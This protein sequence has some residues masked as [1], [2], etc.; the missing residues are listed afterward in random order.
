MTKRTLRVVRHYDVRP[1]DGAGRRVPAE[2]A[3]L[4]TCQC[5]GR[6]IARVAVMEN[7][8]EV[9][10]ECETLLEWPVYRFGRKPS[11]KMAAFMAAAGV[12][13]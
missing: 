1:V 4:R 7:G 9:G 6:R 3:D 5:C 11:R 13:W 8:A 12:V 10:A 2:A